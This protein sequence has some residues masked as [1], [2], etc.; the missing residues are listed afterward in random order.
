[1]NLQPVAKH[2][3]M[4]LRNLTK[5]F[6]VCIWHF[7]IEFVART[8]RIRF[9]GL[10]EI[11]KNRM[12]GFW[13]EDSYCVQLILREL[14]K[15]KVVTNVIVTK[16]R[17]GDYISDMIQKYGARPIRLPDGMEMR[18]FMRG[19]K[20]E[21]KQDGM[22]LAAAMDGPSGPYH[23]PKRLLF[24]LAQE[25]DKGFSY[26]RFS[27]Q[28]LIKTPWRWDK[29]RIPLPFARL[30]CRV[31]YFGPVEKETIRNFDAYVAEH[32]SDVTRNRKKEEMEE[33]EE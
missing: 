8:A 33:K 22:I 4:K 3:P 12:I 28:G 7:Y 10:D 26:A 32:F 5:K 29:Y 18:S 2:F 19:L 15:R 6:V 20:E 9:E 16:E 25:A 24:L 17:R 11:Q 30:V 23:K 13:H 21:S 31:D 27:D 1:M 14:K